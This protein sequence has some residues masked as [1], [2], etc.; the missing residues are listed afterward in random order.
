MRSLAGVKKENPS[1]LE[2]PFRVEIAPK[3]C[4]HFNGNLL[5]NSSCSC[6]Q[7]LSLLGR[8]KELNKINSPHLTGIDVS[9]RFGQH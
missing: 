8:M 6:F 9:K 5:L 4:A 2:E 1:Y 3:R 7:K